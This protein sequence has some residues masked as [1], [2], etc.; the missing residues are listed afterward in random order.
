MN[1][2]F[3]E[4]GHFPESQA[5]LLCFRGDIRTGSD[6]AGADICQKLQ[7]GREDG[8]APL[9]DKTLKSIFRTP[10]SRHSRGSV[11]GIISF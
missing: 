9:G 3:A 2:P 7:D 4:P 11:A 1:E 6:G 10:R 8:S 5:T